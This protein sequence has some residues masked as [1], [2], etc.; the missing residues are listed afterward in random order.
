MKKLFFLLSFVFSFQA[1][2][3]NSV[4][5]FNLIEDLKSDETFNYPDY[6]QVKEDPR[7]QN[8]NLL[9]FTHVEEKFP[10]PTIPY[11]RDSQF[12]TWIHDEGSCINT[13]GKPSFTSIAL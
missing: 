1:L 7:F 10:Y 8:V 9:V 2:A 6:Y 13:R 12:G 4:S 3:L 11:N 5:S